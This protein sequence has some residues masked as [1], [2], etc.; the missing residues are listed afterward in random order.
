MFSVK[1]PELMKDEELDQ[2]VSLW[3][4]AAEEKN[5]SQSLSIADKSGRNDGGCFNESKDKE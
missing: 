3:L 1:L 5:I 2:S 4:S